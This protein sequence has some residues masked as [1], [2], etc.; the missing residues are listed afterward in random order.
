MWHLLA[1]P[2]RG[3]AQ[4][5]LILTFLTIRSSTFSMLRILDNV[6]LKV[7]LGMSGN[8]DIYG[9]LREKA[10]FSLSHSGGLSGHF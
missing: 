2:A 3:V 4:G 10:T 1:E 7:D 9:K 8:D 5:R 6:G